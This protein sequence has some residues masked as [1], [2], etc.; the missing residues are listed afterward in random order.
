MGKQGDQGTAKKI[1]G[2]QQQKLKRGALSIR[3][4]KMALKGLG[5]L[6]VPGYQPRVHSALSNFA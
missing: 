5:Y 1:K 2:I 4:I 3:L 6:L